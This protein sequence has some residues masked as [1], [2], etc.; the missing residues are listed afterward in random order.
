VQLH[1]LDG[2]KNVLIWPAL[3]CRKLLGISGFAKNLAMSAVGPNPPEK[4]T[5]RARRLCPGTRIMRAGQL[6]V[7]VG[8]AER[9]G[10]KEAQRR[11]L[12]LAPQ[13]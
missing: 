5:G 10:E 13:L 9:D 12:A 7:E 11:G 3:K 6:M 4:V 2:S 1:V 8:T